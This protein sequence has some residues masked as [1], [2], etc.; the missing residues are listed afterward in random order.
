M[1]RFCTR[2]IFCMDKLDDQIKISY[3]K[4]RKISKYNQIISV[5]V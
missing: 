4:G 3:T 2:I 5:V 1:N